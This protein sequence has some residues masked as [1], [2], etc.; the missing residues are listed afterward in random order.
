M[1]LSHILGKPV[2][3]VMSKK[4]LLKTIFHIRQES[5]GFLKIAC[6]FFTCCLGLLK[7]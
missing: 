3:S 6:I 2:I 1:A 4:S 7:L 5:P